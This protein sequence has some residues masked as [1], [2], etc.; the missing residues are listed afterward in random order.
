MELHFAKIISALYFHSFGWVIRI[1]GRAVSWVWCSLGWVLGFWGWFQGVLGLGLGFSGL[2]SWGL[3]LFCSSGYL[4][5]HRLPGLREVKNNIYIFFFLLLLRKVRKLALQSIIVLR[6]VHDN[7]IMTAILGSA[8]SIIF[9]GNHVTKIGTWVHLKS[10]I[11]NLV[12]G[13]P[14]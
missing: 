13:R 7:S 4:S 2:G 12:W 8:G 11:T 3:G 9:W 5:L 6:H 1:W 14:I 10:R